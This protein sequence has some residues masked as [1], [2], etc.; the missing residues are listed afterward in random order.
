MNT[1][2]SSHCVPAAKE[3]N[4]RCEV[5]ENLELDS[6]TGQLSAELY[7]ELLTIYILQ[8]DVHNMKYLWKRIPNSEKSK[9]LE[10]T[11]IWEVGKALWKHSYSEAQVLSHAFSWS[12][13]VHKLMDI[14]RES[15]RLRCLSLISDGYSSV[16][17]QDLADMLGL[18]EDETLNL[19]E[20][21]GWFAE[22]NS[23]YVKPLS[24][25]HKGDN[26]INNKQYLEKLTQYILFL[27]T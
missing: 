24:T 27:E 23:D 16:K 8:N 18:S 9:S 12:D 21:R 10:L 14:F 26:A 22:P 3:L 4:Q 6:P 17:K 19:I 2:L 11:A 7:C 1:H 5:L 15:L 13:N 20:R 25:K